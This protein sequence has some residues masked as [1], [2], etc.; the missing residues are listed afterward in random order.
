MH[1]A[2]LLGCGDWFR[3]TQTKRGSRLVREGE[4]KQ[5]QPEDIFTGILSTLESCKHLLG[6]HG[7]RFP[8][9]LSLGKAWLYVCVCFMSRLPG[10]RCLMRFHFAVRLHVE[11]WHVNL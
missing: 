2:Y 5:Q 3:V 10:F 7:F 1:A 4:T 8:V 11:V 6:N 9:S